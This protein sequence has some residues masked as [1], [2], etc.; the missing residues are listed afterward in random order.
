MNEELDELEI[1]Y[2]KFFDEIPKQSQEAIKQK[3][4]ELLK[5]FKKNIIEETI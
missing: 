2:E 1:L 3:L 4:K 5:D